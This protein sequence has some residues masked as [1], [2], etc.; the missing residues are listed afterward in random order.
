[1]LKSRFIWL[2][3]RV[4]PP[5]L[6]PPIGAMPSRR[7]NP[8]SE[9]LRTSSR[10]WVRTASVQTQANKRRERLPKGSPVGPT[11]VMIR[12]KGPLTRLLIP[13]A[14]I[15]AG[16]G[17]QHHQPRHE[18]RVGVGQGGSHQLI[19]L[20]E[21]G[22]VPPCLRRGFTKRLHEPL[23][24]RE[25]SPGGSVASGRGQTGWMTQRFSPAS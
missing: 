24:A 15:G 14:G 4:R 23:P 16:Q 7:M 3:S 20:I 21:P 18:T 12:V 22:K 8:E 19:H 25:D 11:A 13:V 17:T 9:E 2:R 6:P 5:R 10:D 1:M